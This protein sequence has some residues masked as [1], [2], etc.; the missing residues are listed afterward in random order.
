MCIDTT[1]ILSFVAGVIIATVVW[2]VILSN[3]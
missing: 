2:V 1:M 3:L